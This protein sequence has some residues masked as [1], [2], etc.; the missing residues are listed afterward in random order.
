MIIVLLGLCH[1]RDV[2]VA[3][4]ARCD[5]EQP[6]NGTRYAGFSGTQLVGLLR[7]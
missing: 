4:H 6:F 7:V 2:F 1:R 5:D 3:R